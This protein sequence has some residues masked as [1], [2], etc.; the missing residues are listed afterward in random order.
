LR[1]WGKIFGTV[2]DYT[3]V[4]GVLDNAEE[5]KVD[6]FTEKRGEGVNKLVY[7]V[8]DNILEDWIQLPDSRPEQI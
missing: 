4:E 2:K 8:T 3:I 5:I 1:L 6:H 7:W